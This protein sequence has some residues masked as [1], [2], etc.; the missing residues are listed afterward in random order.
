VATSNILPPETDP[1]L[2]A[3]LLALDEANPFGKSSISIP[4]QF[5]EVANE[6]KLCPLQVGF[7]T[8]FTPNQPTWRRWEEVI[9]ELKALTRIVNRNGDWEKSHKK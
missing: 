6:I 1:S 4:S 9:A 5:Q 3:I 2:L 7:G 8:N